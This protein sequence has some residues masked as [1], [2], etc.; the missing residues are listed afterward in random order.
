MSFTPSLID[1]SEFEPQTPEEKKIFENVN[2]DVVENYLIDTLS[3]WSNG[4]YYMGGQ[5]PLK[6][7][8]PITPALMKNVQK[9]WKE[10][11]KYVSNSAEAASVFRAQAQL[12]KMEILLA[13]YIEV[14]KLRI[15]ALLET[16]QLN[17]DVNNNVVSFL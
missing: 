14:Q 2:R 4:K 11:D 15:H 10:S 17:T 6:A 8:D 9:A 13:K 5:I 7:T 1:L 16:T 12:T 3:T